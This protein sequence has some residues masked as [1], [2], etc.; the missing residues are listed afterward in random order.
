M[1][2]FIDMLLNWLLYCYMFINVNNG[3]FVVNFN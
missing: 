3:I 2:I 1:K